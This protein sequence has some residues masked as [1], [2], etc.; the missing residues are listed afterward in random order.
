M[1]LKGWFYKSNRK[2]F[3]K[4]CQMLPDAAKMKT[5]HADIVKVNKKV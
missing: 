5:F 1:L 2:L 4:W 3:H